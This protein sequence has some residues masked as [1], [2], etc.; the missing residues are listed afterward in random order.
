VRVTTAPPTADQAEGPDP[1]AGTARLT[2]ES[3]AEDNESSTGNDTAGRPARRLTGWTPRRV[4]LAVCAALTLAAVILDLGLLLHPFQRALALNA[5]DQALVEWLLALGTRFWTGDLDLVT[6][7]L[8]APDGVNLMSNASMLALGVILTPVTLAFGAPVSFAVGIAANL[9]ATAIGWYLLLARRLNLHRAAAATGAAFCAYA[10]GMIAQSN[11]HLHMTSQWL[12]PVM[13]WGVLRLADTGAWDR[14]TL[15]RV[16]GTGLLLGLVVAGQLFLGEEVLFLTAATLALF[17]V[18]YTLVAPKRAIRAVPTLA[19]GLVIAVAVASVILAYPLW[20]QFYGPQHVPNG[21]FN[22]SFFGADLA[23]FWTVSPLS[24]AGSPAAAKLVSG[25]AEY[26]TFFGVPLL[27]AVGAAT[28]WLWR[29]PAV[30]AGMATAL[31]MAALS[32]G[33]LVTVNDTPTTHA[34][35]YRLLMGLPV[36]DGA[37]PTRFA[38]VAIPIIGYVLAAALDRALRDDRVGIRFAVPVIIGLALLPLVPTPLPT[39]NRTPVPRFFTDGGWRTCVRP[40]GTLVPV[41][42]VNPADPD[43]M[44]WPAA[45]NAEFAIPEGFFIGPYAAG[46]RASVGIYSRPTS[47]VLSRVELTGAVPPVSAAEQLVAWQDARYWHASCFVLASRGQANAGQ[48][49]QTMDA[50]FGPGQEVA[51]VTVWR[52]SAG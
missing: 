24:W 7:L 13:V 39:T 8:N 42:L 30:L 51:D 37:L 17:C 38:L 6:H 20:V 29:R 15:R 18:G 45:A 3:S 48:L 34:G 9:A 31:V 4:D 19:A 1:A 32:L 11:A 36:I 44:R 50:L 27:V 47:Q 5:D 2:S 22:P 35:P 16:L 46:G 40:G 28:I 41:P 49:R 43:K 10:P 52:V 26:N 25:P 33:P 21:P 14:A 12:V 23:G